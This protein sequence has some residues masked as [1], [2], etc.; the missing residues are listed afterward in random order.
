MSTE[1][2][3]HIE[4]EPM[5]IMVCPQCVEAGFLIDPRA[6]NPNYPVVISTCRMHKI[7]NGEY[8]PKTDQKN[9]EATKQQ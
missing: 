2:H 1:K 8:D 9:P 7:C 3:V 5:P 4:R 6:T